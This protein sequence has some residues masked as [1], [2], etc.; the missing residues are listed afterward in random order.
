MTAARTRLPNRRSAATETLAV[1]GQVFEATVGFNPDTGQPCEVF[2]TGAKSGSLLA[3]VLSDTA[4]VVSVALQHGVP[5][6]ALAKS[7]AR[8]PGSSL[9]PQPAS[10]IGAALD[11]LME[12]AE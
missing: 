9:V 7:V 3:A 12:M 10:P 8:Q 1:G 4:V 6:E 2:L 5:A 11:L